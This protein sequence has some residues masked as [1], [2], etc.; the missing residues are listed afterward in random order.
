MGG[1]RHEVRYVLELCTYQVIAVLLSCTC[2]FLHYCKELSLLFTVTYTY[3]CLNSYF[4][5][6]TRVTIRFVVS[7]TI[8]VR[9]ACTHTV[10]EN[11]SID[12]LYSYGS[13]GVTIDVG[14]KNYCQL[15][16]LWFTREFTL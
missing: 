8:H 15:I 12:L 13:V 10:R 1:L 9:L 16:E 2:P 4:T 11:P 5:S 14:V 7:W 6:C 3:F